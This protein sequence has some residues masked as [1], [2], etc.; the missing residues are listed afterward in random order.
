M[1]I[2]EALAGLFNKEDLPALPDSFMFGVA[3][4]DHQCE[5][6]DQN[7]LD[8]RDW[9]EERGDPKVARNKATDFWYR[10]EEDI[11]K[12]K[13]LGCSVFRFSISWSRIEPLP[14]QFNKEA[15]DHYRKLID[16]IISSNMKPIL[17]LH[18][19]TWPIHVQEHGG[20]TAEEF[21]DIY[22]NYVRVIASHFAKDVPYWITFNEPN[23][24]MGGYLKPWW[25]ENYAAPPGLP[26]DATT[27]DQVEAVGK[28]ISNLFR[29]NKKAYEIIKAE[30]PRAQVGVNQYFY[31]LPSWLQQLVNRNASAIK[32]EK[33]L[34][35]QADRLALKRDLIRGDE[36]SAFRAN[37][38]GKDKFDVVLAALTKTPERMEQ[39]AFSDDYFIA[40]QQLLVGSSR[41]MADFQDLTGIE[42]VVVRGTTSEKNLPLISRDSQAIVLD[43]YQKALQYLDQRGNS[44]LLADNTILSGLMEQ[45]PGKYKI[46]ELQ[47]TGSEKY[48]AAI[49]KGDSGLLNAVNSTIRDFNESEDKA[50]WKAKYEETTGLATE[51]PLRDARRLAFGESEI[52][53]SGAGQKSPG[54]IPKAPTGTVLR[55]IQDRGHLVVAVREDLPGFGYR[56]TETGDLEG[57]EITLA[58]AMAERIFG[59]ASKVQLEPVAIQKRMT[60]VGPVPNLLDWIFRQYTILA[61][62]MLTNWWYMGMAGELDEYLCPRGCE[63]KMDF[64]GL[65]YYW[66]IPSL[67]IER[68]QRLIEAAYRHFD[69]APV[70]PGALYDILKDLSQKFPDRPIIICENGSVKVAD[71]WEREKYIREHVKE[72][73]RAI[74]DGMDVAA[75]VYWSITSNREW[76][77]VFSDASDFGLYNIDLDHDPT[78]TRNPTNAAKAYKQIILDRKG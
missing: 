62:I 20:M 73:Q 55:R 50:I 56:N 37:T 51:L 40:R 47:R 75:Y 44:A 53:A 66:G 32:G 54:P 46:V 77:L 6:I 65:D 22:A 1:T 9:W 8:I 60:A 24:L 48:A 34:Q 43:D 27:A 49:A 74:R 39:V 23:L 78:L 71:G 64:L 18:H 28:L 26:K 11:D 19:F 61:T 41:G 4:A 30:N 13:E 5:A 42:I 36:I 76:D 57:I 33:D 10:Y 17:T 7:N 63:N 15:I 25:D 2:K 31:G 70:W 72:V 16:K 14:G 21:P 38:L 35:K 12:A 3:T 45:N 68:L 59:D 58:H 29:A 69:Q 67:H 52:K